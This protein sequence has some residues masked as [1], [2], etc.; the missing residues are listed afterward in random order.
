MKYKKINKKRRHFRRSRNKNLIM[1]S[2]ENFDIS[3]QLNNFQDEISTNNNEISNG[4]D[5]E[6][7]K[8]TTNRY[9]D[10][11][12]RAIVLDVLN[13]VITKDGARRI[14]GIKGKSAVL[15]W[16]RNYENPKPDKTIKN[17]EQT[18]DEPSLDELRFENIRLKKEL[19]ITQLKAQEL[20][21]LKDFEKANSG[22]PN[23]TLSA[24]DAVGNSDPNVYGSIWNWT[25]WMKK[26]FLKI[27]HEL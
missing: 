3:N 9:S 10:E 11:F 5:K 24:E 1:R 14:Y 7:K 19:Q 23:L 22:Y 15:N 17:M 18:V 16:I 13:G 25:K 8:G 27:Q 2:I 6:I 21:V 20:D 4:N 12:K 26:V